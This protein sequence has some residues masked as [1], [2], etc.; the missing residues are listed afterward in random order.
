M[1]FLFLVVLILFLV[2]PSSWAITTVS[3]PS[4]PPAPI[5]SKSALTT[6]KKKDPKNN[7]NVFLTQQPPF[8]PTLSTRGGG[9]TKNPK[10]NAIKLGE[11]LHLRQLAA[12]AI[13]AVL[14]TTRCLLPPLVQVGKAVV[15]FYRTLSIDAIIAQFGLVMCF[16]GGCYPSLIAAIQAAQVCGLPRMLTACRDLVDEAIVAVDAT[17]GQWKREKNP[18]KAFSEVSRI[19]LQSVDP[20]K[21]CAQYLAED[22]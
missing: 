20:M 17:K 8:V 22:L 6:F 13:D 15:S 4:G 12:T 1:A 2:A 21:V 14:S 3:V 18:G 19:V 9:S 16:C 10:K 11:S 5:L 7:K